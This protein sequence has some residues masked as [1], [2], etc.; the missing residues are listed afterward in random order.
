MIK[1]IFKAILRDKNRSL[2]PVIIIS[3]GV[4]LT[5]FLSGFISG[6]MTDVIDQTAR[7]QTGHVKVM[8]KAYA[9][10]EDQIPN[11]LALLK[12]D[13]LTQAL[14]A[15]FPDY[16]WVQRIRFGGLVDAP[17]NAGGSKGQGPSAGLAI[18]FFSGNS[19]EVERLN[20]ENSLIKGNLPQKSKEILIG[21]VFADKLKLQIGD[22]ITF[23]GA[24]MYGSLAFESFTISGIVNFGVEAMDR[25]TIIVDIS[26]ARRMLDM[27]DASGEILGFSKKGIYNNENANLIQNTFNAHYAQNT[28]E[29]APVMIKLKEQNNMASLLDYIDSFS[30]MFVI[31]FVLIMSVVLWNT[32]LIGGLR[33][34][35]EF[36]IRLALGEHKSHIY[37][38][39]LIEAVLIGT[40]G[41]IVGTILGVTATWL[42]QVYGIDISGM[43]TGGTMMMP[44]I[45]RAKFTPD[46]LYIGF[47]PGLVAMVLGNMISGIGIYKRETATLFKELEV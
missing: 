38:T 21:F 13:S 33:R 32:G 12:A 5:I 1:F 25:G 19:G 8:S 11:D 40:I 2:L 36:G 39:L 42:M 35:Q 34:Y 20:I 9:E 47:I 37:K 26:D 41:S 24:T 7:F 16:T 3:I 17:D 6:V 31:I 4:F 23:M 18:D 29:Y 46:L 14:E 28:D 45:M 27:D 43:V 22:T 15:E 30:A 10:N 44:T